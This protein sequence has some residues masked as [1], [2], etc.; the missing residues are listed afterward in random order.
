MIC[1]QTAKAKINFRLSRG[2][3]HL[4]EH[5]LSNQTLSIS[6][7][8]G[9]AASTTQNS[10]V[11]SFIY[12]CTHSFPPLSIAFFLL[13]LYSA[14]YHMNLAMSPFPSR[15]GCRQK[16]YKVTPFTAQKLQR[17]RKSRIATFHRQTD[18]LPR[19]R[20]LRCLLRP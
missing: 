17:I 7:V 18:S 8:E 2:W 6:S 16:R 11:H 19:P 5:S 9:S 10:F 1:H 15:K 13:L 4:L 3:E 12:S 20:L 14:L